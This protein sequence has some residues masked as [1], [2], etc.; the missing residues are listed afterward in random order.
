MLLAAPSLVV[1]RRLVCQSFVLPDSAFY[2]L[3]FVVYWP[4]VPYLPDFTC[5]WQLFAFF[6]AARNEHTTEWLLF[7]VYWPCVP[8]QTALCLSSVTGPMCP[9][10]NSMLLAARCLVHPARN[11]HNAGCSF[12]FTGLG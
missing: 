5:Y 11:E 10:R 7:V 12:S 8:C 3:L 6:R 2:W 9:A 1:F 4:C